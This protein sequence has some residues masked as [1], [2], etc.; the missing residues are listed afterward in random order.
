VNPA[1][2]LWEWVASRLRGAWPGRRPGGSDV[3]V[4]RHPGES[5]RVLEGAI[6]AFNARQWSAAEPLFRAVIAS[7]ATTAS[8]REVAR[9]IYGRL[10]ERNRRVD[11]AVAVYEASVAEGVVGS[12]P[13][14]RL[15]GIYVKQQRRRDAQR[16]LRR[17]V[18]VVGREVAAG[19]TELAMPL[20]RLRRLLAEAEVG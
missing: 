11:E 15:A 5:S 17:A 12:H 9:N 6:A 14:E 16:V 13:Y 19:R 3:V 20:G 1:S 4:L 2:G 8:D 18:E 7:G 10:L